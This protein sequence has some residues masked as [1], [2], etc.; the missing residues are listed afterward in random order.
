MRAFKQG[1][2][3][4]RHDEASGR[5]KEELG[6]FERLREDGGPIPGGGGN[7]RALQ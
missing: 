2:L 4:F 6:L 7:D 5:P 3:D 1:A